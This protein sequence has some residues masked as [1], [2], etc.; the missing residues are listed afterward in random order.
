MWVFTEIADWFDKTRHDN[1]KFIDNTLQPWVASTLN[2]NSPWYRNVAVY[3]AAGAAYALNKFTTTVAAGFVDVLRIGDGVKSGGWG[4]GQDALRALVLLGPAVRA[5]RF[6]ISQVAAVDELVQVGNCTW[7]AGARALRMTG[8]KHYAR[9]G[10]LASSAGIGDATKTSGAFVHEIVNP[11][12]KLGADARYVGEASSLEQIKNLANL[13]P[14]GVVAFSVKWMNNGAEAG[15]TLLAR[16][17][18]FGGIAIIDRTG[19]V[20]SQVSELNSF[21]P[22]IASAVP[23]GSLGVIQNARIVTLMENL[24]SLLN[25]LAV[26][27][28]SIPAPVIVIGDP[29]VSSIMPVNPSTKMAVAKKYK[30]ASGDYLSKISGKVY[31]DS[32]LWPAIYQA[33]LSIIGSNPH[34]PYA[35][36]AGQTLIIP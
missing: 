12:Q 11:M 1:E 6:A 34:N 27:V 7:V 23:Y 29:P 10:D 31:G 26:E 19:K 30:V 9:I 2:E 15:H 28:R 17:Q 24:P 35:L 36:K 18:L 3:S 21:Y 25:V 14:N 32:K 33:N 5:G 4:Y 22:G 8:T 13:N 20:V 16:R